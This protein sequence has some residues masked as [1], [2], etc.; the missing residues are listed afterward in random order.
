[1]NRRAAREDGA[2]EPAATQGG[3]RADRLDARIG[4][5]VIGRNEGKRLERCLA[6][7]LAQAKTAVYVDSGSTDGSVAYAESQGVSV[8]KLDM[9]VPFNAGRARNEGFERLGELAAGL[10]YV[11]FVDG[12]CELFPAWIETAA[13]F[14]DDHEEYAIVAGR[15]LERDPEASVY[16][17]LC[18]MEWR[19]VP[20][21]TPSCG[22]IFL[23]RADAFSGICGFNASMVAGEEPEMCYRF[24]QAGWKLYNLDEDM[25]LHDAAMYRFRQWWR[26][27]VRGGLAYAQG[28]YLHRKDREAHFRLENLRIFAW[29]FVIPSIT[30]IAAIAAGPAAFLA[31]AIYPLQ[32]VR[33][34]LKAARIH[35]VPGDACIYAFFSVL[36]KFPQFLGQ[37]TFVRRLALAEKP[38][39][40]EYK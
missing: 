17:R 33:Q 1:M 6:S 3:T 26:R 31:L 22:G 16:N 9:S 39:I 8:V 38:R 28:C 27:A 19:S 10:R 29:A 13:S 21:E 36:E 34:Y 37:A 7:V 20:G 23:A 30:L 18:D 35:A 15:V 2:G 4:A 25:T 40:I 12:D 24:R 5:V 11:Q 14:L 32:V